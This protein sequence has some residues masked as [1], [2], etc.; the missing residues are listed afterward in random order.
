MSE[1]EGKLQGSLSQTFYRTADGG[2]NFAMRAGWRVLR[3]MIHSAWEMLHGNSPLRDS[4]CMSAFETR[5]QVL[6]GAE[7]FTSLCL[8]LSLFTTLH[9]PWDCF[10]KALPSSLVLQ[11]KTE[12][13][14]N[15]SNQCPALYVGTRAPTQLSPSPQHPLEVFLLCWIQFFL[16]FHTPNTQDFIWYYT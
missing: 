4:Q 12:S 3:S 15:T 2:D 16:V 6:A 14:L 8:N 11:M 5:W 9:I 7:K 1:L 13:I 10:G